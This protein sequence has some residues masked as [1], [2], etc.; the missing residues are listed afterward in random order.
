MGPIPWNHAL[1]RAALAF[2]DVRAE[3]FATWI[4]TEIGE[5]VAGRTVRAWKGGEMAPKPSTQ[6]VAMRWVEVESG[7]FQAT[8]AATEY[9]ASEARKALLRSAAS[10]E[11][12]ADRLLR[13]AQEPAPPALQRPR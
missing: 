3:D 2:S 11:R 10:L 4:S 7:L 6:A 13:S 5:D 8:G 12:D 9:L 1:L